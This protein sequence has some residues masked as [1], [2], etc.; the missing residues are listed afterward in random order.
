[1]PQALSDLLHL[2]PNL[3]IQGAEIRPVLEPGL[4]ALTVG[5][6]ELI[7]QPD[8]LLRPDFAGPTR[9]LRQIDKIPP[10]MTPAKGQLDF[11]VRPQQP[12]IAF[13][14]VDVENPL[15]PFWEKGLGHVARAGRL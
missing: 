11:P 1:M 13:I 14:A 3:L 7:D 8:P 15:R 12:E 9:A 10:L 2:P 4:A 6:K 5:F